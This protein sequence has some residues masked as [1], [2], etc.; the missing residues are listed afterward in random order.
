LSD[1]LEV[2][3]PVNV[4]QITTQAQ[5][6]RRALT[7]AGKTR[8]SIAAATPREAAQILDALFRYQ[9]EIRPFPDEDDDYAIGAEW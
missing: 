9:L 4:A 7:E 1:I 8:Y 2:N 3:A 5:V 6:P